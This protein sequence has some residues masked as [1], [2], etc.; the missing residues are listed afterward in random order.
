DDVS[1]FNEGFGA[2]TG[3][4]KFRDL[5]STNHYA[6]LEVLQPKIRLND[7]QIYRERYNRYGELTKRVIGDI[8]QLLNFKR[9]EIRKHQSSGKLMRNPV[10][11][12][13]EDS[14]KLFIK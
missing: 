2:N 3:S 9:N 5:S 11:P 12:I 7:Y 1:E 14:H 8:Q 4:N 13:I 10:I 6:L